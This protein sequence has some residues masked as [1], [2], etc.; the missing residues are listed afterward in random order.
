[1]VLSVPCYACVPLVIELTSDRSNPFF[2]NSIAIAFTVIV[3]FVFLRGTVKAAFGDSH[4]ISTVLS[5]VSALLGGGTKAGSA[6]TIRSLAKVISSPATRIAPPQGEHPPT[7]WGKLNAV[8]R[9]PFVWAVFGWLQ[10]GLYVWATRYV[11]VA[12]S[13]AI[14]GVY[15]R[16]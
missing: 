5:R 1:M 7:F 11:E 4:T 2:F 14:Y 8:L 10:F 16:D 15:I 3:Q 12:V 13:A 6:N 9:L